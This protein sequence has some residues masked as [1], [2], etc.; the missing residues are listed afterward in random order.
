MPAAGRQ[1][2]RA[3]TDVA[4]LS[5]RRCTFSC[6]RRTAEPIVSCRFSR[7]GSVIRT[8]GVVVAVAA[9]RPPPARPRCRRAAQHRALRRVAQDRGQALLARARAPRRSI[10]TLPAA[11]PFRPAPRRPVQPLVPKRRRDDYVVLHRLELL[12]DRLAP[13]IGQQ[14]HRCPDEQYEEEDPYGANTSVVVSRAASLTGTMLPYPVVVG[15]PSRSRGRRGRAGPRGL[16]H[17]AVALHVGDHGHEQA[18]ARSR[19][20]GAA[21]IASGGSPPARE[22]DLRQG[23]LLRALRGRYC[24]GAEGA[25]GLGPSRGAEGAG[26]GPCSLAA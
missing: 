8:A 2:L 4:P 20:A 23:C 24:R 19:R 9:R 1:R 22:L 26:T 3:I 5:R 14:L 6:F 11:R 12:A 21:R 7:R 16:V 25:S 17:V 18:L 13:P 10:T 15:R